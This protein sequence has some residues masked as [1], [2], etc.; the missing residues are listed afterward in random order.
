MDTMLLTERT[1]TNRD[2]ARLKRLLSASTADPRQAVTAA[3]LSAMDDAELVPAGSVSPDVITM[4]SRVQ[5]NE[6][7]T[8]RQQVLTLC[9]PQDA[10]PSEGF[11]SVLSPVGSALLG[12]RAGS[13]AAWQSPAGIELQARITAVLFQPEAS[14]D[15]AL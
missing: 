8:G 5:L 7:A 4:Y 9:Y 3:L 12:L 15:F 2:H 11:V 6:L 13:V 1:L 14:G 10:L